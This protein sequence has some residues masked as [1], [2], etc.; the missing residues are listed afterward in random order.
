MADEKKT[1]FSRLICDNGELILPL[2]HVLTHQDLEIAQKVRNMLNESLCDADKQKLAHLTQVDFY[3]KKLFN[4]K[5]LSVDVYC[6]LEAL[7]E[8]DDSK[9]RLKFLAAQKKQ[10]EEFNFFLQ[11][12]EKSD[13]KGFEDVQMDDEG[14]VL[15]NR[16]ERYEQDCEKG[17]FLQ[18]IYAQ[19][20]QKKIYFY[21][22]L[23]KSMLTEFQGRIIRKRECIDAL[24]LRCK[25]FALRDTMIIC[26]RCKSDLAPLKTFDFI[27]EDLHYAKCV[28]GSFRKV[29]VKEALEN[30]VYQADREFV[31]L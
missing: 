27:R 1:Y 3:L 7:R 15:E 8:E 13:E 16:Q 21:D 24:K 25:E 26:D 30:P 17:F 14:E 22:D 2:T 5:R 12:D 19:K 9:D 6:K 11:D 20:I 23:V 31:E 28:F 10:E 4:F 18:P 29:D